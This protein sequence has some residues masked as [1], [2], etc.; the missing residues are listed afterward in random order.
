MNADHTGP[1][2]TGIHGLQTAA[3]AAGT[4][5]LSN[6]KYAGIAPDAELYLISAHNTGPEDFALDS[7]LE[8]VR[9]IGWKLGIRGV[10]VSFNTRPHPPLLPWQ[11]E[12][13]AILCEQLSDLGI[14]VVSC[15]GNSADSGSLCSLSCAPS[16][17]SVGGIVIPNDGKIANA[18][19]YHGSRGTTFCG[20]WVP[21]I[22][23]P[24]GNLVLPWGNSR[25]LAAHSY[26]DIDDVPEGYARNEGTSF[27]GPIV[28]GAATCL[29][30]AHP[31][32]TNEQ[33]KHALVKGAFKSNHWS[34]L[35]A[36]VVSVRT[37]VSLCEYEPDVEPSS[38]ARH[39]AINSMPEEDLP[40][41][42]TVD[43]TTNVEAIFSLATPFSPHGLRILSDAF[44]SESPIVRSAALCKSAQGEYQLD[45][46]YL[47]SALQDSNAKVRSAA[48][49][50]I[51]C[52]PT[53]RSH[54]VEAIIDRFED[55]DL[56]VSLLAIQISGITKLP[57]FV[58]PLV[59]GLRKEALA[60]R[61][62][63]FWGRIISLRQVTNQF[64]DP[65]PPF[66]MVE[67]GNSNVHRQ[68][69]LKLAEQWEEW[70]K[71]SVH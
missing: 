49:Y 6:G 63:H 5:L 20:K 34:D 44:S 21:E 2:E 36:G 30:Q 62:I 12:N 32:W 24:A 18:S 46:T 66:Q 7:A 16:V 51:L 57:L 47:T 58:S 71:S 42:G 25:M 64:F 15:T 27:A 39:R 48:L 8:W 53:L 23:A 70:H 28:L 13:S 33:V 19:S 1:W 35:R 68:R 3:A 52:R 31:E 38:F 41:I 40:K 61:D 14:L 11:L 59:T 29:W 37:S 60:D 54:Y 50:H 55:E 10:L 69:C 9:D 43:A 26:K 67:C 65:E 4:G 22:L 17:L 56:D 45:D